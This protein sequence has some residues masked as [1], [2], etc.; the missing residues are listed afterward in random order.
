MFYRTLFIEKIQ[1]PQTKTRPRS[2]TS[3]GF[4]G[5]FSAILTA[6]ANYHMPDRN[7][8]AG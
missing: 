2:M 8:R 4:E 6:R 3:G 5:A 7:H 1:R